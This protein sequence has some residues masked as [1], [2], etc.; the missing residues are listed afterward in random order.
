MSDKDFCKICKNNDAAVCQECRIVKFNNNIYG[1]PTRF[2][3]KDTDDKD[4]Y[5]IVK[6]KDDVGDATF[7][8]TTA[9]RMFCGALVNQNGDHFY[10]ELN[11]SKSLVIIPHGWI[12]WMAPSKV[13]WDLR[14]KQDEENN[15]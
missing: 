9:S 5:Y 7:Y 2:N 4:V 12:E 3:P 15:M 8:K 6:I 1:K 11:G 13:H 10:F 14:R